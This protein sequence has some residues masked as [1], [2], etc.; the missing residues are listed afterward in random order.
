MRATLLFALTTFLAG[1]GPSEGAPCS[2]PDS[3]QCAGAKT[4]MVCEGT[5]W[6]SYP[7]P[8]CAGNTC[9]WKN[10]S[11]GD[12]CP[13]VADTQGWCS[14]DARAVSCFWSMSA[15]AGVFVE[16]SCAACVGGKS[17]SEL[18]RCGGGRCTCQ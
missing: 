15:D 17:L 18:G 11:I 1:C 6:K 14:F 16:Q 8:S 2:A 12:A 9:E 5:S 7:C 3:T 13:R 4:L 10:A